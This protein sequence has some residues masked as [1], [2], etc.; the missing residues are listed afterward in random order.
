MTNFV[1][2]FAL[3]CHFG[4]VA[5]R[6][7]LW[8]LSKKDPNIQRFFST[9]VQPFRPQSAIRDIIMESAI[10]IFSASQLPDLA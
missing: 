3:K 8:R 5:P 1:I 7:V 6:F 10:D 2:F 4:Y 9:T